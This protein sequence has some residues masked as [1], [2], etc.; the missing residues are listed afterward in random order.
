MALRWKKNPR[1][2]GLASVTAGPQGST[3]RDGDE[4]YASIYAFHYRHQHAGK[5]YWTARNDARGVP[6]ANTCNEPVADEATAKAA[7]MAYVREC[8]KSA[9]QPS[10]GGSNG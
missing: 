2:T 4:E 3:L 8:L 9:S 6:L 10:K 5:W 7:A 1:P